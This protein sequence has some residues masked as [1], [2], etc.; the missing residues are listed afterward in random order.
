MAQG[1]KNIYVRGLEEDRFPVERAAVEK[2]IDAS[3]L[4]KD[5]WCRVFAL[6]AAGDLT[7]LEALVDRKFAEAEWLQEQ[8]DRRRDEVKPARKRAAR[9]PLTPR[10]KGSVAFQC[11]LPVAA[12]EFCE[13]R[14]KGQKPSAWYRDAFLR[15]A[16]RPDLA[17]ALIDAA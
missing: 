2:A 15:G 1:E 5:E 9:P 10:P 13:S 14:M 6:A 17:D 7:A 16:G 11:R 3:G 4:D 8:L 12:A